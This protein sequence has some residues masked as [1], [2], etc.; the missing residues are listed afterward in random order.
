MSLPHINSTVTHGRQNTHGYMDDYPALLAA[1]FG[2][3]S[4]YIICS[5]RLATDVYA[6]WADRATQLQRGLKDGWLILIF[7]PTIFESMTDKMK[8]FRAINAVA[9][10]DEGWYRT[11]IIPEWGVRK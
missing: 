3:D 11:Y 1:D 9:A 2:V 7:N 8:A 4:L 5:K 10:I 6:K